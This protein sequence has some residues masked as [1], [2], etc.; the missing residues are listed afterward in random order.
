MK[1]GSFVESHIVQG[2]IILLIDGTPAFVLH[3]KQM[4]EEYN[5]VCRP[6]FPKCAV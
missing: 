4:I 2:T 5:G 6:T 3:Q 1:S